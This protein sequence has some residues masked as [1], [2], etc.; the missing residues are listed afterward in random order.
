MRTRITRRRLL[1]AAV[2]SLGLVLVGAELLV[3]TATGRKLALG[4]AEQLGADDFLFERLSDSDQGVRAAAVT[5]VVRRGPQAVPALVARLDSPA[6]Q[7]RGT[8]AY[9]LGAIGPPAVDAVPALLRTAAADPNG[10]LRET[11]GTA[12]GLIARGHPAVT[13]EVLLMLESPDE[14]RRLTAISAV[15][16]MTDP[17][18]VPALAK[19]LKHPD[20]KVREDAA[21]ALGGFEPAA[22]VAALPAL[23]ETLDDPVARVR[24]EA[25]EAIEPILRDRPA[26]LTPELEAKAKA[27][28]AKLRPAAG[29]PNDD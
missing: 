15:S 12:V 9:M 7:D 18:A 25:A 1:F 24:G 28:L 3:L 5:A 23:V 21:E 11:A 17:R 2:I 4:P 29:Q 19:L 8:A 27:G 26:G 10:G 22:A 20:P 16:V 13:S 14:D 6:A